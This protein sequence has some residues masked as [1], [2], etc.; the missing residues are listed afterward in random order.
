M[1]ITIN[2]PDQ[3]GE[4]INQ[5]PNRDSVDLHELKIIIEKYERSLSEAT[6]GTTKKQTG[7]WANLVN[8]LKKEKLLYGLSEEINKNSQEIRNNFVF[9]CDE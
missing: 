5:L 8:E 3:V 1:N 9:K 2:V 4:A 6:T 7:K